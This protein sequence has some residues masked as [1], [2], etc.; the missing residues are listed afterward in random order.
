MASSNVTR[1]Y[2]DPAADPTSLTQPFFSW[3]QYQTKDLPPYYKIVAFPH[4]DYDF[5]KQMALV[6][7]GQ[8]YLSFA[9][10][11]EPSIQYRI[12]EGIAAM[13]G[14]SLTIDNP[15]S[16]DDVPRSKAESG[17]RL[18]PAGLTSPSYELTSGTQAWM[19]L[20]V[21]MMFGP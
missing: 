16:L 20:F 18:G 5:W 1:V 7:D 10:N 11:L 9:L 13:F 14:F 3:F 4:I 19:G 15:T 17:H 8:G 21:G 6:G 2:I 12:T